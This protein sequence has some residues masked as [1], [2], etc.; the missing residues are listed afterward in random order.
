MSY[1]A[2]ALAGLV[3]AMLAISVVI[4][5]RYRRLVPKRPRQRMSSVHSRALARLAGSGSHRGVRID[6]HCTASRALAGQEFAFSAAPCLP[7]DGCD[8]AVCQCGYVG[9]P[10]RR[11]GGERRAEHERRRTVRIGDPERRCG[12][13]RRAGDR[14][15]GAAIGGSTRGL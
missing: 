3:L 14:A 13:P 2:I 10:E 7:V 1:V 12:R 11:R 9:L 6:G 8:A 15:D 4:S 5:N